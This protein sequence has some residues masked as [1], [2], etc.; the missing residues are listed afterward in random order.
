MKNLTG[1][2]STGPA[3]PTHNGK[4]EQKNQ[5]K[6]NETNSQFLNPT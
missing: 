1:Q 4:W 3:T 5:Q 6:K 2:P